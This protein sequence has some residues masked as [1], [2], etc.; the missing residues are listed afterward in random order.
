MTLRDGSTV[1]LQANLGV[2]DLGTRVGEVEECPALVKGCVAERY[3]EDNFV[4]MFTGVYGPVLSEEREFFWDEMSAIRGYALF[5]ERVALELVWLLCWQEKKKGLE[6]CSAMPILDHLEEF[7]SE[8][9]CLLCVLF[10]LSLAQ[11]GKSKHFGFIEFES[12][13]VAKIVA[14]C[15]HNHLL[16]EH[17]LQVHVV[18]PEHVHP[19]LWK[20]VN[21]LYKPLDRVQIERK[22]QNKERT[23]EK[24]KKLVE[25]IGKRDQKRRKRI[26]AAGIDYE[27]PEIVGISRPA[28]KKI[29]FDEE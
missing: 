7:S 21:R 23:L 27:C 10:V 8:L 29:R 6:G 12:P 25:G 14:E 19:K 1:L 22:R 28:S 15:M 9:L 11:T 17:I 3:C 24:Q 18:P 2:S 16:F 20:G 26:E 5:S 13:E 4:W